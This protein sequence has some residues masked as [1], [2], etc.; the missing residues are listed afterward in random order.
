MIS[1]GDDMKDDNKTNKQLIEELSEAHRRIAELENSVY[2]GKRME[3]AVKD[4]TLRLT[5]A[6]EKLKQEIE[7]R[8]NVEKT[9]QKSD[10][11]YRSYFSLTDD[12]MFSYDSQ[13]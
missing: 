5:K 12:V 1:Y 9:L 3:E 10:E 11:K 6:N 2:E 4:R 8:K 13:F 7:E